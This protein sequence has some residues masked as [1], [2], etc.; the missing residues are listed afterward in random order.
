MRPGLQA[1]RRAWAHSATVNEADETLKE[2]GGQFTKNE[3]DWNITHE[4]SKNKCKYKKNNK[5]K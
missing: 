3:M 1:E 4:D 2:R 5:I